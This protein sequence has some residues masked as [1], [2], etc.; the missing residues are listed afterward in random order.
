[1]PDASWYERSYNYR[2]GAYQLTTYPP[3][4]AN[5]APSCKLLRYKTD[6]ARLGK[7]ESPLVIL[8]FGAAGADSGGFRFS[9]NNP[10][11]PILYPRPHIK[12]NLHQT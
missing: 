1:M 12:S 4:T 9:P 2:T 5:R 7:V 10:P 8:K 3:G 6:G 11:T